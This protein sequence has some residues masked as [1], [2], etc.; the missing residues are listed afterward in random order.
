MEKQTEIS[1]EATRKVRSVKENVEHKLGKVT[2]MT[3]HSTQVC[4]RLTCL[5]RTLVNCNFTQV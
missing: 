1:R 4:D 5:P 2:K 3:K